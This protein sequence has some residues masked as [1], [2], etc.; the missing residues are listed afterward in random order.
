M[1][2][3]G[4]VLNRNL[5]DAVWWEKSLLAL[6]SLVLSCSPAS[7]AMPSVSSRSEVPFQ[8]FP[9]ER[10]PLVLERPAQPQ[11]HVEALGEEAGIWGKAG[12]EFEA[13]V[14]PFKLFHGL[15]LLFS[16][17]GGSTF[18][19][20]ARL[21]RHQLATPHMAQLRL[22][23]DRF[24]VTV[25]LFVPRR[26]PGLALLMDIESSADLLIAVR[27]APSL[28]PM[29]MTTKEKPEVRWDGERRE[30]LALEK[31]RGVELRTSSPFASDHLRLPN[32]TEEVRLKVSAAA[33]RAGFIPLFFALSWPDG[34]SAQ[35]T[36][37]TLSTQ[38]QE[39]FREAVAHYQNLL[40]RAPRVIS[41]NPEVNDALAWSVVSLDQLRVHN[42]FLGCGLVSGYSSSGE[43]TR[44][45]YAWFF[46][47]P[48][49]SSWAYHRAGLSSHVKEAFRFLQR[50]QRA[51]GKTVHEIP[52]S[53]NYQPEFLK[54]S[55]YAY[56]HTDGP[57]YFLAAY[58]H[59]YRSTG[60]IRFIQEE[61][62]K[63]LKTLNWCFSVVDPSDA[64]IQIE[65]KDWGSAESS[66]AVWKDTQ[67]EGMWVRALREMESLAQA[68][69]DAALASRCAS[70]AQKA[71]ES[72]ERK[73]WNE[74]ES[75]YLWGLDR[76][77][78]PL[79][80]VVPY[81]TVSAWMGSL[82]ADRTKRVL[83]KVASSDFRTDWGVRTLPI[84]DPRFDP[85][86]YQ[87][88]SVW[89][90]WNAGVIVCD[91]R[92]GQAVDG[93]RNWLSM[94]RLRTRDGL[95][96][97]PEVLHGLYYMPLEEGSPHQMFSE[98]AIQNG[99]YDGLL[100][101]EVD[102]PAATLKLAP[103]LPPMWNSL[104]VE[105][106][107]IGPGTL[108]LEIQRDRQKYEL[109]LDLRLPGGAS[110]TLEPSLPAGS[111]IAVVTLDDKPYLVELR[112]TRSE[113]VVSAK[114]PRFEGSRRLRILHRGGI[115]FFPIDTPPSP[116]S[117]SQNLRI[118][119]AAL[120]DSEW[121]MTLEGLPGRRYAI[122]FFADRRLLNPPG[123]SFSEMPNGAVR[124][125][126][127]APSDARRMPSGFVRWDAILRWE[128]SE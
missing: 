73:L 110:V 114:I 86:D 103:R 40:D 33:A 3:G 25:T 92:D 70:L 13:W 117:T 82:R 83:E 20:F 79:K 63:I 44:P 107:P 123:Q 91:Y 72:I 126:L 127:Q 78:Q 102:V 106:I 32:G 113:T 120:I 108:N 47:E 125:F 52:Q 64:L 81:F 100:G 37:N 66:F 98:V 2:H 109:I 49:L 62:P 24:S 77:G 6:L 87:S 54:T 12:G 101:L 99:F 119:R 75:F 48:T 94:V 43:G 84:S 60:D 55:P 57:V 59:Y 5:L 51:D 27:F 35:A 8:K 10:G 65:P 122:D 89:P 104:K 39:L 23:A 29:L 61:W 16:D 31:E 45:E 115:D 4:L 41:P 42:P 53:L 68:I 95:G 14:Y 22:I 71:S 105:R 9:L 85:S 19:P 124:V 69:G 36:L 112:R 18:Q 96:P 11:S 34:P 1:T 30:L 7:S 76:T 17:D 80:S 74:A 90:V 93:F 26:L 28:A 15:T 56:I 128:K 121:L 38:L 21:V 111:T 46:D 67:L 50:F 118:I 88:G 58:G 97:M 116:G